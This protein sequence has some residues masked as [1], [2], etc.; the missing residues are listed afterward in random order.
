V[1]CIHTAIFGTGFS[2]TILLWCCAVSI[3]QRI[4]VRAIVVVDWLIRL[5]LPCFFHLKSC[6]CLWSVQSQLIMILHIPLFH[7]GFGILS[8][9]QYYRDVLCGFFSMLVLVYKL[10]PVRTLVSRT[11]PSWYDLRQ[12]QTCARTSL[13]RTRG[14]TSLVPILYHFQ[15]QVCTMYFIPANSEM[16]GMKPNI[17]IRMVWNFWKG[18]NTMT[19]LLWKFEKIANRRT[20]LLWKFEKITNRRTRLVC[21][22]V[23]IKPMLGISPLKLC[24]DFSSFNF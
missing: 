11:L 9:W 1:K 10:A 3:R 15:H 16:A 23:D 14:N 8:K 20:R 6:L 4:I 7:L 12:Y 18:T 19:R 2:V 5:F 13:I 17:K 24:L 21:S 22:K